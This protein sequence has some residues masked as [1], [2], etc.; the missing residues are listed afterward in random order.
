MELDALVQRAL[1]GKRDALEAV[2]VALEPDIFGLCTRMLGAGTEAED[3]TQEVL[4]KLLT[5]LASFRGESSFRTWAWRVATHHLLRVRRSRREVATDFGAIEALIDEGEHSTTNLAL[6]TR[7]ALRL[8]EQVRVGCTEAML[9]ALDRPQRLAYVLADVFDLPAEEAASVLDIEPA[10]FRKR[11]QRA[12]ERLGAFLERKCGLANPLAACRCVRQI[13]VLDRHGLLDPARPALTNA[14]HEMRAVEGLAKLFVHPRR[15][16]P[17][18]VLAQIRQLLS[19][20]DLF[21]LPSA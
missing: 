19:S 18:R 16:A 2:L 6:E 1:E 3:A 15:E 7:D 9:L 17:P 8:A 4:L 13:P 10:T 21:R 20:K 12:R 5:H 14:W 11:V